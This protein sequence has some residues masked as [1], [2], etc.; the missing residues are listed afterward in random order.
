[1][2]DKVT[3]E[4]VRLAEQTVVAA[5][6]YLTRAWGEVCAPAAFAGPGLGTAKSSICHGC[7]APA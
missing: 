6:H 3:V 4:W 1:M 7:Q 2:E 5:W